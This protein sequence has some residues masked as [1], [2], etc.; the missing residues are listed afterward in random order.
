MALLR[1][2]DGD[3][4]PLEREIDEGAVWFLN[5][6]EPLSAVQE[7]ERGREGVR[8]DEGGGGQRERRGWTIVF[9]IA[10]DEHGGV[11]RCGMSWS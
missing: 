9:E 10:H 3:T 6:L 11:M 7:G 4:P 2:D 8:G 5:R 1:Y